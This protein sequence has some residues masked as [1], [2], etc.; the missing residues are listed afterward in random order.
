MQP[1][2]TLDT[3]LHK[4]KLN[5]TGTVSREDKA[6][7]VTDNKYCTVRTSV[8]LQSRLKAQA[9]PNDRIDFETKPSQDY[10]VRSSSTY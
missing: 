9:H 6:D 2:R 1:S 7:A 4:N 10:G 8:S 5:L 3:T